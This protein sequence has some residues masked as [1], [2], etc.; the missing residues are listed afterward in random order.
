MAKASI[1]RAWD[2]SRTIISRD[3][4]LFMPIAL[5]MFV[6]P[7]TLAA[8]L[9]PAMLQGVPP[10]ET[11]DAVLWI[12]VL[13]IG[14][15]GRLAAT[16][17][18]L[19][20]A[21]VGEAIRQ[22]ALRMPSVF[23]ALVLFFLPLMLL[24]M[25]ILPRLLASPENPDSTAALA[26]LGI[27]LAGLFLGV[28]LVLLAGQIAMGEGGNPLRLMKR[29]W[30]LSGSSWGRLLG[31]LLLYFIASAVVTQ[32]VQMVVGSIINLVGGEIEPMSVG[33]LVLGLAISAVGAAFAVLFSVM[34]ARIYVQLAGSGEPEVSVPASRD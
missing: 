17:L 3:S 30:Q 26:F 16:R 28:R 23:A 29:N 4:R 5:A 6:L 1:S 27:A 33:A 13:I 9:N 25:P 22:G 32:V 12:V 21:S 20:T 8:V 14:L 10:A 11:G 18:A 31:F 34:L 7:G 24:M 19:G 2:E 15:I